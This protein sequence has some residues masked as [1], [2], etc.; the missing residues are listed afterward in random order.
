MWCNI[1][2]IIFCFIS[3]DQFKVEVINNI[4]RWSKQVNEGIQKLNSVLE[5][6]GGALYLIFPIIVISAKF[7]LKGKHFRDHYDLW[8]EKQDKKIRKNQI[9]SFEFWFWLEYLVHVLRNQDLWFSDQNSSAT[10]NSHQY[11]PKC[12]HHC[13][14]VYNYCFHK[15]DCHNNQSLNHNLLHH[16]RICSHLYRNSRYHQ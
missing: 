7:T 14:I 5:N 8:Q 11:Y 6:Y 1:T 9:K 2:V 4:V 15:Q 13:A 16:S 10:H 12:S 3:Y